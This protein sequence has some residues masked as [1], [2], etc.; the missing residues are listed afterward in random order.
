MKVP[1]VR[2]S[3]RSSAARSVHRQG[4]IKDFLLNAA[5]TVALTMADRGDRFKIAD[6]TFCVP[7]GLASSILYYQGSTLTVQHRLQGRPP[8]SCQ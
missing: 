4:R 3:G 8:W 2:R 1:Q 6:S 5:C 7:V